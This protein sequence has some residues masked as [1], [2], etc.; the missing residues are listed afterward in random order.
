MVWNHILRYLSLDVVQKSHK[1]TLNTLKCE[2]RYF[3]WSWRTF[4]WFFLFYLF[5]AHCNAFIITYKIIVHY[6]SRNVRKYANAPT[7]EPTTTRRTRMPLLGCVTWRLLSLVAKSEDDI[8]VNG[9]V[10]WTFNAGVA[11]RVHAFD[12]DDC[13]QW[14]MVNIV[15][16]HLNL[17]VVKRIVRVSGGTHIFSMY[18]ILTLFEQTYVPRFLYFI[19]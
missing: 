4:V 16:N 14:V 17:R 13:E 11:N 7:D 10:R 5:G 19:G 1:N 6:I 8:K 2:A 15:V 3:L 18:E 9:K 12:C